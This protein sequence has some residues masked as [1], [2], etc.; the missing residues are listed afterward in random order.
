MESRRHFPAMDER[1]SSDA[2][3]AERALAALADARQRIAKRAHWPLARHVAFGLLMGLLV[4]G[5]AL[6]T[7]GQIAT[8]ILMLLGTALLVRHDRR[9]DGFFV[10]GYRAGRTRRVALLFLAVALLGL[11]V[12]IVAKLRFGLVWVP[13]VAGAAIAVLG[14][15]ASLAW[16]RAYRADLAGTP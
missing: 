1:P 16:E 12:A 3:E 4:A 9:R 6:P 13:L 10:N 11:A 8:V 15:L 14:T 2:E 7:A 5:Y